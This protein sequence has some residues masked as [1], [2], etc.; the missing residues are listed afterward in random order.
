[1]SLLSAF[2][3]D[4]DVEGYRPGYLGNLYLFDSIK[5]CVKKHGL[6]QDIKDWLEKYRQGDW[7]GS[8]NSKKS[9]LDN[10][11]SDILSLDSG[12]GA[13]LLKAKLDEDAFGTQI[14]QFVESLQEPLLST[15]C[16]LFHILKEASGGKPSGKYLKSVQVLVKVV[17]TDN[18]RSFCK[19]WLDVLKRIELQEIVHSGVYDGREFSYSEYRYLSEGNQTFAK[20]LIWSTLEVFDNEILAALA[21]YAEKCYR[22]IPQKGPMAPSVGN[23]CL[24]VLGQAELTGISHLSR[25]R[26]RIRQSNTQNLIAAYIQTYAEQTGV[27]AAEIE[28][29]AVPDFGLSQ[30]QAEFMF[31]AYIARLS[32]HSVSKVEVQWRKADGTPLKAKPTALAKTHSAALKQL[33][34]T[35]TQVQKTLSAQRDRLDRDFMNQRSMGFEWFSQYYLN[36]P[37]MSWLTQR[38][39]WTFT[40]ATARVDAF[41]LEGQWRDIHENVATGIEESTHVQLWHPIQHN[42][43]TILAWR[44]LLLKHQ[45]QQ[46]LKQAFREVYLLTDAEVRTN[47]YSNR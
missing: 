25:L 34:E 11:I 26:L 14:N 36:H 43:E 4:Q 13:Q 38:L 21:Q 32:I 19:Q 17:G 12:T 24:Y 37:L 6:S 31:D 41:W 22:K 23:A 27:S 18:Y 42:P 29:M 15:Y 45:I 7:R 5:Q 9:K 47:T 40:S 44:N 10:K 39:I 8:W 35:Q 28:D 1:M 3:A 2:Y 46:P 20:G 33:K 30:G 16:D